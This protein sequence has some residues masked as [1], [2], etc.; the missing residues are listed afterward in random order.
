MFVLIRPEVAVKCATEGLVALEKMEGV[1]N[2]CILLWPADIT[3]IPGTDSN[4]LR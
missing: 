2:S 1:G 4:A 3:I